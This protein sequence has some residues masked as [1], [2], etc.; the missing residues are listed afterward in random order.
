[1]NLFSTYLQSGEVTAGLKKGTQVPRALGSKGN[2]SGIYPTINCKAS[3]L[4][5][6]LV[7]TA[8]SSGRWWSNGN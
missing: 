4:R 8:E 3:Y 6:M 7:A 5:E 1:M 2:K